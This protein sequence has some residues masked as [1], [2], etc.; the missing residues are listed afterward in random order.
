MEKHN[1]LMEN[2][3]QV[4][5]LMTKNTVMENSLGRTVESMRAIGTWANSTDGGLLQYLMEKRKRVYGKMEDVYNGLM[6]LSD[7]FNKL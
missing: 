4:N 3:T 6:I 5:M 2:D 7:F 1:G